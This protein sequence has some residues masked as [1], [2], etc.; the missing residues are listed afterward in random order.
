MSK[1]FIINLNR[2]KNR[3]DY[4]GEFESPL[5]VDFSNYIKV[6]YNNSFS[7]K[8]YLSVLITHG[9]K[10]GVQV[11]LLLINFICYSDEKVYIADINEVLDQNKF[12]KKNFIA[13]I[14]L[15]RFWGN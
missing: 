8:Y 5:I 14:L 12:G 10:V 9:E 3:K 7:N 6:I 2:A 13:Y 1:V 11:V 15:Y 4:E